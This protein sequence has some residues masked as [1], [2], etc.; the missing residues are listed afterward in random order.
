MALE[1]LIRSAL[2]ANADIKRMVTRRVYPIALPQNCDMPAVSYSRVT[3]ARVNDLS[4]YGGLQN[5]HIQVDTWATSYEEAV[6][7][8]A[9]IQTCMNGASGYKSLLINDVDGYDADANLYRW[10]GEF[11]VWGT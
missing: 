1:T 3:G 11:S 2:I 6:E 7:L 5:A 9:S 8:G 4:G 10:T